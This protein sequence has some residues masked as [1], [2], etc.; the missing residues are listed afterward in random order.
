MNIADKGFQPVGDEF[1]RASQQHGDRGNRHFVGIG[2]ELHTEC[3][4]DIGRDHLHVSQR[5]TELRGVNLA[6]L[7]RHLMRLMHC[8]LAKTRVEIG[9]DRPRLERHSGLTPEGEIVLDN[10]VGRGKGCRWISCVEAVFET[11]IGGERAI[12]LVRLRRRRRLRR[13]D[14]SQLLPFDRNALDRIFRLGATVR[15]DCD[16]G[17]ALPGDLISC[18][19]TLRR[20][21]MARQGREPG[22]PGLAHRGQGRGGDNR[23]HAGRRCRRGDIDRPDGCMSVRASEECDMTG[24]GSNVVGIASAP[25]PPAAAPR[26]ARSVPRQDL[27]PCS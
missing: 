12:D 19:R 15:H 10:Q 23:N 27:R 4:A 5:E 9:Q 14:G 1:D 6:H 25:A 24:V 13:A 8:E 2:G 3:A 18:E 7:V 11:E 22:L 20:R 17:L 21:N 26:D 16:H